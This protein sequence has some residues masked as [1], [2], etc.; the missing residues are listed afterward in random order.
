MTSEP[1]F[2]N[3]KTIDNRIIVDLKYATTDNFTH[4]VIYD[5]TT[6]I[7]RTPTAK[8]LGVAAQLLADEG[9]RLKVW[10]AYRPVSA[11]K[12]LFDVFPDPNW[13]LPPNPNKSHQKGVTF[14][15][16]ITDM[17]GNELPMQS[18]FDAFGDSARR[19][20][21]RE[22]AIE[23]N[24]Q[25]LNRAMTAAGFVGYSEEWWDYRDSNMD[26]MGPGSAN[27]NDFTDK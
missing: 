1:L 27:P 7:A 25:L 8:K 16:T 4:Q 12:K 18:P 6:A 13:V 21:Q 3:I 23:H 19:S 22:P 11:Q 20:Y 26:A 2:T 17:D 10:D 9:Y 15:L 14:D 5:F 24:Y